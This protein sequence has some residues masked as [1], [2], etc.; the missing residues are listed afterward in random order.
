MTTAS[1]NLD[2]N[3]VLNTNK[4]EEDSPSEKDDMKNWCEHKTNELI[5]QLVWSKQKYLCQEGRGCGQHKNEKEQK[6]NQNQPGFGKL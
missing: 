3:V 6:G 4:K 1:W 2:R 5:P